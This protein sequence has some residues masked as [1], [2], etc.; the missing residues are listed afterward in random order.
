MDGRA[1]DVEVSVDEGPIDVGASLNAFVRAAGGES[2]A[3]ASFVGATRA[4]AV[5][6]GVVARLEYQAYAA[7]ALD[8]MRRACAEARA[9]GGGALRR[10]A[11]VRRLAV[12]AHELVAR[13]G[14]AAGGARASV[15][16][17]QH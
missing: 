11:V 1:F 8:D 9:R 4:D 15:E 12:D 7:M 2:G 10:A 6:G 5:D 16:E 17:R 13:G 14:R 3:V